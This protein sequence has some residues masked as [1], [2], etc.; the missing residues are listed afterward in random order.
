MGQLIAEGGIAEIFIA[1]NVFDQTVAVKRLK[2]EYRAHVNI[3]QWFKDEADLL[4]KM[5]HKNIVKGMGFEVDADECFIVM[6]YIEGR[7]ISDLYPALL[8]HSSFMRAHVALRLGIAVCEGLSHIHELKNDNNVSLNLIHADISPQNIMVQNDGAIK[9]VDLGSAI[10]TKGIRAHLAPFMCIN[11]CYMAPEQL[12]SGELS[13]KTDI[14]SLALVLKEIVGF[15]K[16]QDQWFRKLHAVLE[17]ASNNEIKN[18]FNSSREMAFE[19]LKLR[20]LLP[21]KSAL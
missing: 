8:K 13:P 1:K 2:E 6:E 4:M 16:N 12:R 3:K 15:T 20:D 9:I 11:T 5:H 18:R 21:F 10:D 17:K 14:Y 7:T 19:F